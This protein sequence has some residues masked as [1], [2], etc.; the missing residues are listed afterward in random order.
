MLNMRLKL[1]VLVILALVGLVALIEWRSHWRHIAVAS[2]PQKTPQ[3]SDTPLAK[4]AQAFFWRE[5]HA[6]HY[7][8]IPEMLRLLTAAY[9]EQPRDPKLPLLLAHTH[10]W[11]LSERARTDGRDPRITEHAILAEKYFSEAQALNPDDARILGWLGPVRMALGTI[12]QRQKMVRRG[13]FDTLEGVHRYPEFNHFSMGFALSNLP[14]SDPRFDQGVEH[15]WRNLDLCTGQ[16]VSR[17]GNFDYARFMSLETTTGPMRACWNGAIAPHNF[18]GFF[19]NM[20]DMLV[21]QGRVDVAQKIYA[22]A[23]FSKTYDQWPYR[24]LLERSILDAPERAK[25]FQNTST[26]APPTIMFN[27]DHSCT[28]C[29]AR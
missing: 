6:G 4:Q 26:T 29:H 19:L 28:G 14:A 23:R 27:S 15:Q 8:Q 3:V 21:K 17:D 13:Y 16:E 2:A 18:E 7:D 9:L 20:G 22:F 1:S 10:L 5:F 24:E 12:D 11:K 25:L